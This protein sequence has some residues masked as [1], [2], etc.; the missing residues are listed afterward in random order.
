MCTLY[1]KVYCVAEII[2]AVVARP[3]ARASAALQGRNGF[4]DSGRWL[5]HFRRNAEDRPEP[6]W[7]APIRLPPDVVALLVRSLEQFRLG[8]GGGPASLIAWNAE[9]F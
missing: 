6:D 5:A 8:D 9:T 7:R 3:L 1:C 2:G 4:M